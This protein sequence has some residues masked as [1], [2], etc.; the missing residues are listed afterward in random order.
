MRLS[1]LNPHWISE[2]TA[3]GKPERHGQGI[4][5]DCAHCVRAGIKSDDPRMVRLP[6]GFKIPLDGGPPFESESR[7]DGV[8]IPRPL[9]DRTGDT[10]ES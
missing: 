10:F 5:F 6:V 7:P 1:E 3:P 4:M 9:W 2:W 8:P